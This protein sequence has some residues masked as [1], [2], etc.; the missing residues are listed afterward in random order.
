MRPER[1]LP[2]LGMKNMQV[3]SYDQS[4]NK[5]KEKKRK[6]RRLRPFAHCALIA[7]VQISLTF[8]FEELADAQEINNNERT[9]TNFLMAVLEAI[10][11]LLPPNYEAEFQGDP[12]LET[13]VSRRRSLLQQAV[14]EAKV[15]VR[16]ARGTTEDEAEQAVSEAVR[17]G[18]WQ[19][20][21]EGASRKSIKRSQIRTLAQHNLHIPDHVSNRVIPSYLSDPS[22]PDQARC[23]S[24]R[25]DAILVTPC[26]TNPNRYLTSH[27]HRV[28]RSMRGNKEVRSSATPARQLHELSIQKCHIHLIETK[29]CEETR[30][31]AQLQASQ[32]QL[33]E[34]SKQLQGAETTLHTILLGVGGTIKTSV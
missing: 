6:L 9:S 31:A 34:L 24:S 10:L 12:Q 26:L 32:Q 27:T 21:T 29:Y 14:I 28:L 3:H 13:M 20:S 16:S 17:Q 22:F 19:R 11:R 23:N 18:G 5:R 33:S 25:P 1:T 8:P 2:Q 30:P 4:E 15:L 7:C